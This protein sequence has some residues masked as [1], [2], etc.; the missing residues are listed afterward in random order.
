MKIKSF[1]ALLFVALLFTLNPARAVF[2]GDAFGN[3]WTHDV[4]TNTSTNLGNSG[5]G[6]FF[7]IAQDP[8]SGNLYGVTG[9]GR[10]A[11]I[12]TTNGSATV[13]GNTGAFVNGLTF[14]SAGTLFASGNNALFTLNLG[15][16][17]ASFVGG[18]GFTSSGDLAFDSSGNLYM[19][20]I[21]GGSDR[22]VSLNPATGAGSLIGSIGFPL[23]Y[24]LNYQNSTLYGFTSNGQTIGIN[25][26][27]GLGTLLAFNGIR[28][29][30]ADGAGGVTVP[31][32]SVFAL[33]AAGLFGLG[34]V[35]RRQQK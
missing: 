8:T 31:E 29:N 9:T 32:P 19:S 5:I 15:T 21:G 34:F 20:A 33:F 11:S 4:S 30:G 7:D 35:R 16:G 10:F 24:G 14:D 27:T 22:L 1:S 28:T 25:T 2:I 12:N 17:G 18:T 6:A 13:L 3:L 23:V 26:S